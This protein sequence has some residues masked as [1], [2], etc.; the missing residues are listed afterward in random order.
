MFGFAVLSVLSSFAIILLRKKA[1]IVLCL[2]QMEP[3]AGMQQVIVTF[4]RKHNLLY[5]LFVYFDVW[6]SNLQLYMP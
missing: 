2:C 6:S 5:I 3:R 4:S 1:V